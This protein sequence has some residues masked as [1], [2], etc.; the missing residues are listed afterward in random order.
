MTLLREKMWKRPP[1]GKIVFAEN[2]TDKATLKNDHYSIAQKNK[3]RNK[4]TCDVVGHVPREF[5]RVIFYFKSRG[6]SVK[7]SVAFWM[8]NVIPVQFQKKDLRYY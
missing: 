2:E 8:E 1:K 5:S 6:G 4:I 7:Q 3:D